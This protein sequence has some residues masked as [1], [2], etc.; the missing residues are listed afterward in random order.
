M[1]ELKTN[2]WKHQWSAL[3]YLMTNDQCAL[4]TDM[5]TGKTKILIDTIVNRGFKRVLIVTTK[6]SCDVWNK[7]FD[8][9]S[10]IPKNLR[11][12][13]DELSTSGKV[14]KVRETFDRDKI[15][16]QIRVYI[17]N[18]DSVWR[19]PFA[20]LVLKLPWDCVICDESHRIK[21]PSSKACRFL[22]RLSSK[23]KHRYIMSGTPVSEAPTDIYGQYKFL[24]PEVFG[25]NFG[26]FKS[27][28]VNID[29]VRSARCGFPVLDSKNPYKNLDDLNK[30]MYS[31]AFYADST[32]KLPPVV[33]ITKEVKLSSKAQ[34]VYK[35]LLKEGVYEN[36]KGLVETN[37]ILTL[38]TRLQQLLSGYLPMESLD[39]SKKFRLWFD[40]SKI[41][42]LE[43]LIEDL[44]K[45]TPIVVFAKYRQD[46]K[47]IK[48][49]CKKQGRRYGEISGSCNNYKDWNSNKIDLI[50]VQYNSGS[51]SIDLTRSQ[52]CIYYSHT[53]SYGLYLQSLKRT[54]RPGQKGR[55]TYYHLVSVL[56]KG[57]TVDQR[58][59]Q[60]HEQKKNLVDYIM[61]MEKS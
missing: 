61:E 39:F 35:E 14:S 12:K 24:K 59:Q 2:P 19:E 26:N 38:Y 51:E 27:L 30:R 52:Y 29:P 11:F 7:E 50:A 45:T 48:R 6:K 44:P 40:K 15:N 20:S 21:T 1:Y 41:E 34:N 37:N 31:C 56:D 54:H 28:Y 57:Q 9:H 33:H 13:L 46:F 60:A 10:N 58:I 23:V 18:Y 47:L 3:D 4:F 22:S 5:G 8:I 17:V 43:T 42:E 53:F 55:V 32:V 36:S 16:Q 25:T 49:L